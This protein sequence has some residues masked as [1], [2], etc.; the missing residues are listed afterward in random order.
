MVIIATVTLPEMTAYLISLA[1][2]GLVMVA[3]QNDLTL[4]LFPF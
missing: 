4:V 3:D 1:L 2:A